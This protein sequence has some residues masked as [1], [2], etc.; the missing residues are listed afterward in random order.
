MNGEMKHIRV[1]G[2]FKKVNIWHDKRIKRKEFK[3][4]D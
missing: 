3:V 4:A 2:C 1:L